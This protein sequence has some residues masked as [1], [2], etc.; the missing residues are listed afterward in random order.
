MQLMV[1]DG[2]SDLHQVMANCVYDRRSGAVPVSNASD[3][4]LDGQRIGLLNWNIYKGEEDGWRQDFTSLIA[5]QDIVLLQEAV[6]SPEMMRPLHDASMKWNLNTAFYYRDREAGVMTASR[7]L[8]LRSCGQRMP[9]P[10]I[11]IPKTLLVS[12]FR[13]AGDDRTLLVANIHGINF[14]LGTTEYEQQLAGLLAAVR[15]HR[16]PLIVAGDFNTWS[17]ERMAVVER[18]AELLGLQAVEYANHNRLTMFGNPLDHVFYRGLEVLAEDSISV[19]SSDHNPIKV[20]FRILPAIL[21][22]SDI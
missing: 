4:R 19:T 14:T 2:R 7:V 9:E 17:D 5:D 22:R 8:P 15:H 6:L 11:R 10:W 16:G 21:A 12:E 1:M 18:M 20:T 3:E 13:L